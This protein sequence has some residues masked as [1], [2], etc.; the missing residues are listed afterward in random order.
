[1]GVNKLSKNEIKEA[2]GENPQLYFDFKKGKNQRSCGGIIRD[3]GGAGF[4][5]FLVVANGNV[6]N[7]NFT[8]WTPYLTSAAAI[9][10]G[11]Y[12]LH[13]SGTL[14]VKQ[15]INAYNQKLGKTSYQPEYNIGLS[16]GGLALRVS[17]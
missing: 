12:L 1:M 9:G 13:K 16:P 6:N 15:S 3:F 7:N 5:F 14:K 17:F 4:C 8:Y 11:G 10:I 2:L